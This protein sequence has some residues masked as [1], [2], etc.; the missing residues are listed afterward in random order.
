M[1]RYFNEQV[2]STSIGLL[3]KIFLA[4]RV[5]LY[6]VIG[7]LSWLLGEP[8]GVLNGVGQPRVEGLGRGQHEAARDQRRGSEQHRR[9]PFYVYRL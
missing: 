1:R 5:H 8:L 3:Q 4:P 9:Q 6:V 7:L 2:S